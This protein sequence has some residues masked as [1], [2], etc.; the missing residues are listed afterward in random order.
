MGP[1]QVLKAGLK[2]GIQ[3]L[4]SLYCESWCPGKSGPHPGPSALHLAILQGRGHPV[5]N[6]SCPVFLQSEGS[7]GGRKWVCLRKKT[8][9]HLLAPLVCLAG[10]GTMLGRLCRHSR[11]WPGRAQTGGKGHQVM[12]S[13][14]FMWT[15]REQGIVSILL[16]L[17]RTCCVYT[18]L[19]QV[20]GTQQGTQTHISDSREGQITSE[21][22]FVSW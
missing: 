14:V 22:K 18:G 19:W 1:P 16:G 8:H 13:A 17:Q 12:T 2:P 4:Y 5:A 21:Q 11:G 20:P 6:H 9:Q 7:S 10:P 15:P 3:S